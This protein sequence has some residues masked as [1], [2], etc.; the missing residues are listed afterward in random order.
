MIP[1]IIH[2]CWFG[3][4]PLSELAVSCIESWKKYLPEYEIKEWNESNFD[5]N[6]CNYVKE[7]YEAGMWAFVSDY[8]RFWILYR[9]GGVYFD[10]DVELIKPVEDII[11]KGPFMG[12]EYAAGLSMMVN[13]GLGLAVNA[14][15]DL[16]K[17]ILDD[18]HR[19][20]FL[21][22]KGGMD[23]TTVVARVT[24]I[25]GLQGFEPQLQDIQKIAGVY[26]YPPEYFCPQN[27]HTGEL[28][29]TDHTYS[30]HHYAATWCSKLEKLVMRIERCKKGVNSPEYKIRRALSLPFRVV[31]KLNRSG[32]QG[33]VDAAKKR[34]KQ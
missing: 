1:K 15:L 12:C 25:L 23:E 2:Y 29:I 24:G 11:I 9:Y 19:S 22:K 27:Y 4:N 34:F 14:G 32:L 5:V 28:N 13:A 20:H 31:N 7:A 8:A 18:Y 10:T 30:I 6:C 33:A 21:T 16:Y 3:G 26:I 17:E